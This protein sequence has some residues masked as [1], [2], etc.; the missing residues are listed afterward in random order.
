MWPRMAGMGWENR[1]PYKE[2]M[3]GGKLGKEQ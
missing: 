1:T 2:G 3:Q